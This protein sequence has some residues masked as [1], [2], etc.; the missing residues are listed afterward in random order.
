MAD[1]PAFVQA[2][3]DMG[4]QEAIGY[5]QAAYDRYIGG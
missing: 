2:L 4:M 1:Y 3:N 5:R